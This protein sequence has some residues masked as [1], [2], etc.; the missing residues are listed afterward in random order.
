MH[1]IS[2]LGQGRGALTLGV[3]ECNHGPG[4]GVEG[5]QEEESKEVSYFQFVKNPNG[6]YR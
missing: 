1:Q 6:N 3:Y 5:G 4:W 2:H